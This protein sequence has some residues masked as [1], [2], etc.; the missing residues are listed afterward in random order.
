VLS[1]LA[2]IAI[3]SSDLSP[4]DELQVSALVSRGD[5]LLR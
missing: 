4:P 2:N 5:I 3:V 1:V